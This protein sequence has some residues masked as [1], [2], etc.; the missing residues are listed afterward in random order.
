MKRTIV[1]QEIKR[2]RFE[3]L[4]ERQVGRLTQEEMARNLLF[5]YCPNPDEPERRKVEGYSVTGRL[6]RVSLFL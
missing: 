1:L 3:E 2:M 4:Y 6:V 5:A